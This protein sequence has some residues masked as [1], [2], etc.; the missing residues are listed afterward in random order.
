MGS[1][2]TYFLAGNSDHVQEFM[3]MGTLS[4]ICGSNFCP[5]EP[6]LYS[7]FSH[8]FLS[9]LVRE[10]DDSAKPNTW[11]NW[12]FR[13]AS[14]YVFCLFCVCLSVSLSL[15]VCLCVSLLFPHA[16]HFSLALL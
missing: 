14:V 7:A 8:R 11:D 15:C 10:E 12:E 1:L 4:V 2:E 3:R 13:I 6:N 16:R 9:F 5:F